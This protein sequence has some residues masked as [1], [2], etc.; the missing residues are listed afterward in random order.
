[1]SACIRCGSVTG[2]E[3]CFAQVEKNTA[4]EHSQGSGRQKKIVK[5]KLLGVVHA[6]VCPSCAWK[7]KLKAILL[8]I[9]ITLAMTLVLSFFSLFKARPNRDIRREAASAPTVL[10]I[11]A[12]ILWIIG[13]SI[14]VPLPLAFYAA[15]IVRKDKKWAK[16]TFLMPLDAR[17]YARRKNGEISLAKLKGKTPV[18]TE[19]AEKLV[20][21]ILD[22]EREAELETLIEQEFTMVSAQ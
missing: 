20:P 15:E 1:M 22:K 2:E 16:N 7:A 21:A 10:P 8:T 18:Q 13:L 12:G 4:Y 6:S 14:Y 11:V 19:L 3:Y 5:E 17:Y 9:P